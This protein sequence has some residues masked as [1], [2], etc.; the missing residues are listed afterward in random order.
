MNLQ[1]I[2]YKEIA[3]KAARGK[4]KIAVNE[5]AVPLDVGFLGEL[6]LPKDKGIPFKMPKE[7]NSPTRLLVALC[8]LNYDSRRPTKA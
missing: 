4:R 6:R 2:K 3:L 7:K 8:E 1:C 5:L